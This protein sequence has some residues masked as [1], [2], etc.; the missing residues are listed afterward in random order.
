MVMLAIER[1]G[2]SLAA[3]VGMLGPLST[4]AMGIVLLGEPMN[5][6]VL[7]GTVLVLAGVF[8]CSRDRL[9]PKP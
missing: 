7:A 8:V 5:R 3:Q 9:F 2:A 1:S 4:V 6:W